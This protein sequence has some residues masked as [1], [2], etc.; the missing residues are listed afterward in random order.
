MEVDVCVAL[1]S[2]RTKE[3]DN[4]EI[5]ELQ[6]LDSL[7]DRGT[8]EDSAG[9]PEEAA[10]EL[11][12]LAPVELNTQGDPGEV[13]RN[14][15]T[16]GS[17]VERGLGPW[18]TTLPNF[19][20]DLAQSVSELL[21]EI[22]PSSQ[23]D[24]ALVPAYCVAQGDER[25][26]MSGIY[27]PE[28]EFEPVNNRGSNSA[29]VV[30]KG[31]CDENRPIGLSQNDSDTFND[32]LETREGNKGCLVDCNWDKEHDRNC[33]CVTVFCSPA[34]NDHRETGFEI[35][36]NSVASNVKD[37]STEEMN[38]SS[39]SEGMPIRSE[40]SIYGDLGIQCGNEGNPQ[41]GS[42]PDLKLEEQTLSA[43]TTSNKVENMCI[44]G[45]CA[46]IT[47]CPDTNAEQACS[48]D[49]NIEITCSQ[50]INAENMCSCDNNS[51]VAPDK[52]SEIACGSDRSSQLALSDF[53]VAGVEGRADSLSPTVN[54]DFGAVYWTKDKSKSDKDEESV[55]NVVPPPCRRALRVTFA[56]EEG[57]VSG[58]LDPAIP[59]MEGLI[60]C[61]VLLMYLSTFSSNLILH[62]WVGPVSKTPVP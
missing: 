38:T 14:A 20:E 33:G 19:S 48:H 51:D 59:W 7:V 21:P 12:D 11:N 5:T 6:E 57:L 50:D 15:M 53:P 36:C 42:A 44:S 24:G 2:R 35:D 58:C 56:S 25:T 46:E 39:T 45:G 16:T 55:G 1:I 4:R 18:Q 32:T 9:E 26:V 17:L 13:E 30:T 28:I 31:D 37:L 40:T 29:L 3:E 10:G 60:F 49:R 22:L 8:D 23:F 47:S 54:L 41:V 34:E 43:E 62:P 52:N 27:R 61:L